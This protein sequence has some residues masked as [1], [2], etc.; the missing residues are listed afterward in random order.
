[1]S[2]GAFFHYFDS[3]A[4][5]L[6]AFIERIRVETEKPLL[7]IL[8]DPRLT[9]IEK[10]QGFFDTLDTL[11][12]A[13]QAEVVKLSRV[14]YMDVNAIVRQKVEK[15]TRQQR[16]PLLTEV[17]RQGMAEGSFN[18]PYPEQSGEVIMSLLQGMGDTH[19]SLLLSMEREKDD[20]YYA[21]R[22][23]TIHAAYMD[24]IERLL[25]APQNALYRAGIEAVKVWI[26]AA[27]IEVQNE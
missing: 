13:R 27:R 6:E 23:V 18:T 22:I 14:W 16:A 20:L 11:R 9:A 25:G 7:P 1:M 24:A 15:A 5:V 21:E 17:V 12:L 26:S 10:L 19:A 8:H 2:N 4:S 3:K